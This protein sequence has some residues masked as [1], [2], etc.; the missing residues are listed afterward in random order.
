MAIERATFPLP[1]VGEPLTAPFFAGAARDELLIPHCASC[2]RW[3]WYPEAACGG[4][5]GGLEWLPVSGRATLFSWAVVERAFLPAYAERVPFV[6]A[7]AALEEDPLVRICTYLVDADPSTLVADEPIQVV[8]RDLTF[9]TVANS[10]VRVPMFV[11]S[12]SP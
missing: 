7:L 11:L 4:C 2:G 12:A 10:S 1:D 3:V 8:F 9:P 5:A 6:T